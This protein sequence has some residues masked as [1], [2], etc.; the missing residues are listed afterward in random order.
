[1]VVGDA[2]GVDPQCN[3]MLP[4]PAEYEEPWELADWLE[5]NALVGSGRQASLDDVRDGLRAGTLVFRANAMPQQQGDMLEEIAAG[6]QE[7]LESRVRRAK[8]AYPFRLRGSSLERTIPSAGRCSS[9]YAFCLIISVLSWENQKLTGYFPERIFEEVSSLVAKEYLGGK[10]LR[11]GWPRVASVLPSKFDD[12]VSG[13]CSRMEE[14]AGYETKNP[15]VYR[16][17]AGLDIVAWRRIDDRQGKLLMF[18]ACA[19]GK[20]WEQKL[21]ELQPLDFCNTYLQDAITPLPVKAFFTPR[22]VPKQRWREYTNRAGILFDRCRVSTLVP[23]LPTK[24]PHGDVREW[25][26]TAMRRAQ[27]GTA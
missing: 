11:F 7:E 18:G 17:D 14:G 13:L 21:T 6:V 16:G 5:L 20:N 10:A 4:L 22:V 9:T 3:S 2:L 26:R 1:M 12:A 27:N 25:M 19:T 24:R 8:R 23:Q 15:S